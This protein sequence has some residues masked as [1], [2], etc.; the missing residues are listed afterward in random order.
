MTVTLSFDTYAEMSA[1][2]RAHGPLPT[3]QK[4][5]VGER[6]IRPGLT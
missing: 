2:I 4:V 1:W 3:D 5:T 6:V